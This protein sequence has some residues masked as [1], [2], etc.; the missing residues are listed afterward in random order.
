MPRASNSVTVLH[1]T[2]A[3]LW[4]DAGHAC[5]DA[6]ARGFTFVL[7]LN[8][9]EAFG[10]DS[11]LMDEDRQRSTRFHQPSDR[12]NFVLGR[13]MVHHV[14]RA[15]GASTPYAFRL[16]PYGKPFLPN[17]AAFSLSHSGRWIACAVSRHDPIG[18]DLETFTRLGDYRDLL[19]AATHP[20]ERRCIGEAMPHER[21]P[22]FK[23]CWTRKEAIL[24]A[25]GVG[26][27][28][29]LQSIDV[30]LDQDEPLLS[31][32]ALL[33]VIDLPLNDGQVVAALAQAP[34]VQATVVMMMDNVSDA[35]VPN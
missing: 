26:L 15:R 25:T 29:D 3:A 21:L 16:G 8:G 6:L 7:V 27:T 30:R 2:A 34:W 23:R 19:P 4:H 24:K 35:S 20:A 11:L 9:V 13:T 5:D 14:V 18:I 1:A 28:D 10:D 32:P 22:M 12:H 31:D 33:R 17:A